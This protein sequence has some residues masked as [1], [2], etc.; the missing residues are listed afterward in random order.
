[1][2]ETLEA[3]LAL[4]PNYA[5]CV[6]LG[7]LRSAAVARVD[8]AAAGRYLERLRQSGRRL[9]NIKPAALSTLTGW[10]GWFGMFPM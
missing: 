7:Q 3:E 8:A 10:R 9:G 2:G 6:R 4:N 1:L 5:H